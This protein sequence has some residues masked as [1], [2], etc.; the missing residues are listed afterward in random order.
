MSD[1]LDRLRELARTGD[2]CARPVAADAAAEIER[3]R[4]KTSPPRRAILTRQQVLL[5]ERLIKANGAAVSTNALLDA[6]YA[7]R[8]DGGPLAADRNMYVQICRAR[9]A[10]GE[11]LIASVYGFGYRIT[12]MQR[13]REVLDQV[14]VEA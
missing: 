3:L 11:N 5:L 7:D 1:I 14:R 13:A 10:V 6:L 9:K 8:P 2:G 4:A 12:D